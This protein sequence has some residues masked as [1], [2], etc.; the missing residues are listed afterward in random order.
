MIVKAV[1]KFRCLERYHIEKMFFSHCKRPHNN[2]NISLKRLRD[3]GYLVKSPSRMPYVYLP[4]QSSIK[5]NSNK[6]DHF[7]AIADVYLDLEMP[8][9]FDVEPR[10]KTN[11]RPDI[12]TFFKGAFFF[13]EVQ[14]SHYT[15]KAM[16]KKI[17][18][19]EEF[20]LSNEW[21]RFKWQPKDKKIFPQILLFSDASYNIETQ[22]VKV[23]Q[24]KY[25]G[26]FLKILEERK[27]KI[28]Q[29]EIR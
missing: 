9:V 28:V 26:D 5:R 6:I 18:L 2:S 19:Y 25:V 13:I 7:L 23:F 21:K 29:K 22:N 10:Y 3:R 17:D 20:Y 8:R 16:Q 24:Y 4:K 1:E 14:N 12:F 15:Q 27:R 11:V